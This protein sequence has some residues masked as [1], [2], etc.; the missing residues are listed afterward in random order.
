MD[1]VYFEIRDTHFYMPRFFKLFLCDNLY[2][3]MGNSY[4]LC[5]QADEIIDRHYAFLAVK[6]VC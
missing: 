2:L 4:K 5:H 1:D 6:I 3:D